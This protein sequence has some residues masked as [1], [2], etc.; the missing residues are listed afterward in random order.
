MGYCTDFVLTAD[1]TI[2]KI[3][4]VIEELNF[5]SMKEFDFYVREDNSII[6]ILYPYWDEYIED[7][8]DLSLKIPGVLFTLK[9]YGDD[10]EDIWVLYAKDGKVDYHSVEISYP[11]PNF[12]KERLL[13]FYV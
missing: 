1:T 6:G 2:E 9:G 4:Q 12:D 10:R 3:K 7:M 13:Y 8:A 5:E 11:E